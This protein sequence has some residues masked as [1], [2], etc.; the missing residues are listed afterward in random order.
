MYW[1]VIMPILSLTNIKKSYIDEETIRDASLIVEERDKIG[2]IGINGSGKSTLFNIITENLS[3]DDGEIFRK[4]DLKIG[5][6]EQ[7]LNLHQDGSIYDNCLS[8][9]SDLI[10]LEKS[11]REQEHIIAENPDNLEEELNKYQRMQ[12]EF[13]KRDG[14]SFHSRIRGT[15]I[16]LGFSEDDFDKDIS[17]LSGGQK[18]RVALAMLLLEDADLL[19]LD[20]PTNHLVMMA[21]LSVE[22]FVESMELTL[23]THASL[24]PGTDEAKAVA[25]ELD[26]GGPDTEKSYS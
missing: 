15:L 23:A 21:I 18:S 13:H 10:E 3:Y 2:L 24:V 4:K 19:L 25:K 7:Q 5:Y 11:L 12:D 16:G 8:I 26:E 14:Y 6:L 20:E 17:T 22:R 1:E 9:F